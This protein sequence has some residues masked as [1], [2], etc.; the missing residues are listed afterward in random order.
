ME[1]NLNDTTLSAP[2][3]FIDDLRSALSEVPADSI[4]SRTVYDDRYVKV[5]AF[6]FAAGQ[7]LSE[8]T[9]SR[10][11]ILHFIE[12]EAVLTLGDDTKR[13]TAG[14]WVYMTA[15]LIHSVRAEKPLSLLLLLLKG[16]EPV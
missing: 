9:A 1:A 10:P 16:T 4:L 14:S 11:A 7:E 13:A 6:T 15:N 8:H 3:T 12:G 2:Y 5:T